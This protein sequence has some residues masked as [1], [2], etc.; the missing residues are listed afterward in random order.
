[1]F[2]AFKC[3]EGIKVKTILVSL[4]SEQT[5]PNIPAI[6]NFRPD[7]LS[8]I[9]TDA[10]ERKEKTRHILNTLAD[11]ELDYRGKFK[12]VYVKENSIPG[13]HQKLDDS[14]AKKSAGLVWGC[15]AG[16]PGRETKTVEPQG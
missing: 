10:M 14:E 9:S 11:M 7:E 13:C 16:L 2:S 4:I 6:H 8:F 15:L 5:I 12:T 3:R 1:M